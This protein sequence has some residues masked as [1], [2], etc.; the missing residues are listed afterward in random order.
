METQRLVDQL[1][2]VTELEGKRAIAAFTDAIKMRVQAQLDAVEA[3]ATR[4]DVG[5]LF[6]EAIDVQAAVVEIGPGGPP[7]QQVELYGNANGYG[8]R[9]YVRL[10]QGRQRVVV[11]VL[12]ETG[13]PAKGR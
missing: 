10:R 12:P 9:M 3:L 13:T 5:S 2:Q 8:L 7:E 4:G 6:R 1:K 11:L